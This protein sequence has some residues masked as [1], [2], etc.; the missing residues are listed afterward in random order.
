MKTAISLPDELF[1]RVESHA[2]ALGVSRSEFFA[3][4]ATR[5]L[6]ALDDESITERLNTLIARDGSDQE[7]KDFAAFGLA[8][9]AAMTEDDEW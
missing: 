6:R 7:A 8:R 4:A 3:T 2:A 5:Y 1:E 9:L